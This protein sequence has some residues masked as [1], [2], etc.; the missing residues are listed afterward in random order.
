MPDWSKLQEDVDWAAQGT[1]TMDD[2][3][4]HMGLHVM[5]TMHK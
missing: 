2:T 3:F 4:V 5:Y 1:N